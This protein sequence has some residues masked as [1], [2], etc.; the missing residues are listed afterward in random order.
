MDQETYR[1]N[2]RILLQ[3]F[4]D[5]FPSLQPPAAFWW[6]RWMDKYSHRLIQATV[7]QVANKKLA[8]PTT[9]KIGQAISA[10]LRDS[11]RQRIIQEEMDA[12]Q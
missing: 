1:R 5:K 8:N 6:Q 7:I 4:K 10:I 12:A 11:E 9:D 3:T 2:S